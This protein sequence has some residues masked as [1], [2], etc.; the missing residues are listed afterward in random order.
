MQSNTKGVAQSS[1]ERK[2][3]R[4]HSSGL[5]MLGEA[6]TGPRSL[7]TLGVALFICLFSIDL[8]SNPSWKERANQRRR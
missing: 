8:Q 7:Q 4:K 6:E 1:P 3:K 5:E 2:D